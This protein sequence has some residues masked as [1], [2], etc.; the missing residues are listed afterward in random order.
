MVESRRLKEI[1]HIVMPGKGTREYKCEKICPH[2]N[3]IHICSHAVVTAQLNVELLD[4]LRWFQQSCS[5]KVTNLPSVVKT[6][7]PKWIT[8]GT[9]A[10]KLDIV[11]PYSNSNSSTISN[12]PRISNPPQSR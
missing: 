6:D 9:W 8:V 3:G 5:K 10:N 1:P 11:S 12:P 4:V 2:Y 7:M